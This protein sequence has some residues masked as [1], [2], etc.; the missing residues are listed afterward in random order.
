MKK[1]VIIIAVPILIILLSII[2]LIIE[3]DSMI[4]KAKSENREYEYYL[5]K[6]IYGT[7]LTSIINKTVDKNEKNNIE[8]N[9]DGHYID[10]NKNSIKI[11]VKMLL[12]N[13]TYPMEEFYKNDMSR[14]IQNFNLT[15]FKCTSIEY[16]KSTGKIKKL[17]FEEVEENIGIN[18]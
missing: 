18:F 13:K 17:T 12:T 7:E 4:K 11:D 10:N 15:K 3:K 1:T 14:F 8:K 6:E 16:H 9:Q 2:G 5:N